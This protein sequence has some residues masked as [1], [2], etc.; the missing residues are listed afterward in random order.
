MSWFSFPLH[1]QLVILLTTSSLLQP[2]SQFLRDPHATWCQKMQTYQTMACNW[3]GRKL[4][5]SSVMPL[6][7][8]IFSPPIKSFYPHK[9]VYKMDDPLKT[10]NYHGWSVIL[11]TVLY[12]YLRPLNKYQL[13][14]TAIFSSAINQ[15]NNLDSDLCARETPRMTAPQT[16]L[17]LTPKQNLTKQLFNG[18]LD[19]VSA[20]DDIDV[21]CEEE[22]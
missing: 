17:A 12:P 22:L 18:K 15:K 2:I 13:L 11:K 20:T 6:N 7:C 16:W 4:I 21:L 3:T 19:L 9:L 10:I 8:R 5:S 1:I 14:T